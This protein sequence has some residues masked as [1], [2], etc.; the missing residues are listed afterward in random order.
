MGDALFI[1]IQVTSYFYVFIQKGSINYVVVPGRTTNDRSAGRP[2]PAAR[3]NA[4]ARW[5]H[6]ASSVFLDRCG[7]GTA[8]APVEFCLSVGF[9]FLYLLF[10]TSRCDQRNYP[11]NEY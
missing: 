8:R 11:G 5:K 1:T 4:A 6:S 9:D 7:L 2:R 3:S 10:R